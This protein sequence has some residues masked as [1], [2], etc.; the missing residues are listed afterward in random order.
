MSAVRCENLKL[1]EI[2]YEE[3]DDIRELVELLF[4]VSRNMPKNYIKL[5]KTKVDY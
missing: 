1:T 3:D 5:T 2:I 4:H